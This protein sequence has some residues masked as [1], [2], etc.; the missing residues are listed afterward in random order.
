MNLKSIGDYIQQWGNASSVALLSP[1]CTFFSVSHIDGV[2]GYRFEMGCAIVFGDPL[3]CPADIPQ[4]VQAFHEFCTNKVKSIVY[5]TASEQFT[6]WTLKNNICSCAAAIGN[7][8]TLDP[9]RD[10]CTLQGSDART[11]RHKYISSVRQGLTFHE[12][13]ADASDPALEKELEQVKQAWI[14]NR[15]GPQ[16]CL[17]EIDLFAHRINKRYFYAR[18]K[19]AI[20]GFV[21]L[22][23]IDAFQGWTMNVLMRIPEAP[24]TV[25]EFLILSVLDTLRQEECPFFSIGMVPA[26]E[27]G[28]IEGLRTIT[29]NIVRTIFKTAAKIFKFGGRQMYWK[30]FNPKIS[31]LFVVFTRPKI[32]LRD[33]MGIMRALKVNM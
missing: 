9:A 16:V 29:Q 11:I 28:R 6:N 21:M 13:K 24:S 19:N 27:L 31:P 30:K 17:G 25:S 5:I 3:C 2:I 26:S 14:D 7:E 1:T 32:S 18:H 20:I 22:N 23:R 33:V 12:Y 10:P 4:F 8:L 15:K